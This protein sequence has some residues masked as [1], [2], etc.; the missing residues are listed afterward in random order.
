MR[1]PVINETA[2]E[3]SP[4]MF[5]QTEAPEFLSFHLQLYP[6]LASPLLSDEQLMAPYS[7]LQHHAH[8]N[9]L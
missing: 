1:E 6:G 9:M 8:I 4:K 3:Q 2:L 7:L 5:V